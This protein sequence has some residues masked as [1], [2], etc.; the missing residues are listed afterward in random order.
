MYE[1]IHIV[2]LST[3]FFMTGVIWI[4]QISVY[5]SLKWFERDGFAKRHDSYRN[6]IAAVVTIPMIIEL[7]ASIYV[8]FLPTALL[9]RGYSIVL[10]LMLLIIWISTIFIQ[11]P[12]H[13]RL[14]AGKDEQAI[15]SLVAGNWIRTALWTARSIMISLPLLGDLP[16]FL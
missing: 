3:A 14:S 9:G 4:V 11:V 6:R 12:Q 2:L 10:L 15:A 16:S 1:S 13:E 8:V 5:P 7:I